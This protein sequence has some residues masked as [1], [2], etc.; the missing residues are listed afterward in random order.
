[1]TDAAARGALVRTEFAVPKMDCPTEERM[2]RMAMEPHP[3]VRRVEVDLSRRVVTLVHRGSAEGLLPKMQGLGLGAKLGAS[4]AVEEELEATDASAAGER[5]VLTWLLLIN[6]VM[7]VAE[8]AAGWLA[9]SMGLLADSLDML[10]DAMVYGVSLYAVGAGARMQGRA[11]RISGVVQLLLACG[12]LVEVVRRALSG[13]EPASL[14]MMMGAS[15]ALAANLWCVWLLRSHREGGVHM[16][17]SWIFSTNDALANLGVVVAGALVWFT[18][19]ALPD[20]IIGLAITV[21]VTRGAL[22]ILR[23]S[24]VSSP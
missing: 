5:R 16:Q 20:L 18:G 11:A 8:F 23:L 24:A 15:V 1:M 10:G 4:T 12:V 13:G 22:R 2:V 6:A 21:F 17:A 19:S 14:V 7:F 3:G 9:A